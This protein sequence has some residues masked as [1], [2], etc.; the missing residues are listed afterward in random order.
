MED[1]KPTIIIVPD[2]EDDHPNH[3][4][5]SA[6]AR[7]TA[8]EMGFKGDIYT[9]LVHKGP[10]WPKPKTYS[11]NDELLPSKEVLILDTKWKIFLINKSEKEAKLNAIIEHKSQ[12]YTTYD[13]MRLFIRKNELLGV[14]PPIELLK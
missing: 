6:F 1:S 7:Y 11:P 3:T 4:A 10:N 14:Y 13:Y 8:V 5:T 2:D 9:Y 12:L